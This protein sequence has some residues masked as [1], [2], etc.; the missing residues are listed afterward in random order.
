MSSKASE[1]ILNKKAQI[2][3]LSLIA[4]DGAKNMG[5]KI[6]HHL[7]D[8]SK[9]NGS[10]PDTFLV[11]SECPRFSSGDA[12]GIIKKTIR[13]DDLFIIV[14]VGN[15]SC[16]Y[17]MFG[18]DNKM[19]PDDHYQDLKRIIQAAG[20]KARRISVIMPILYGGRQHRRNY[21]ESL[22]C[23]VALKELENMGVENIITF[24]AHD[25]RVCNAVPLM[26]FDNVI[27]SYQVLKALFSS[28][29]GLNVS[30][31]TFMVVS[32][33]E[34]AIHRNMYY[35][36]VL[37]V[38]LGMFYKRR[39]YSVVVNGRNPIVAHEYLGNSVKGKDVF[40]S[41]DIISSGESMLEVAHELKKREAGRIF[42]YA[43]YPIFTNGLSTF[44]KAYSEGVIDYVFGTNLT[45]RTPSLLSRKWFYEVDV[46]K[47]I[48][49]L[50]AALNHGVSTG[51]V[52]DPHLKVKSLL[53]EYNVK[54]PVTC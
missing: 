30:K 36:S 47:Y 50:I 44:D 29:S 24:D 25:A 31:E 37:G 40:I 52:I 14:D 1:M 35:A 15:Y 19:S 54:S 38:E 39:D 49:Y 43:T 16:T 13:G 3:P 41:D 6:D 23:A 17:N 53:E 2:A 18:N 20:G 48:A 28:V 32:P 42:V 7:V 26:G 10:A 51:L 12:K 11:K 9:S 27:P 45:Y 34:G 5:V 8:W 33:D 4:L 21:R 46:S 22:D